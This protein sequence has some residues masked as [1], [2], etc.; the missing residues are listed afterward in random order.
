MIRY[1]YPNE[2]LFDD[3]KI[4][5]TDPGNNMDELQNTV[6]KH[7]IQKNIILHDSIYMK[8]LEQANQRADQGC[9]RVGVGVGTDYK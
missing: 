8:V 3:K 9:L 6:R 5:A 7:Q 1:H 2:S 4:Q